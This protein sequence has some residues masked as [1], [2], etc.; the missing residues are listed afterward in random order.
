MNHQQPVP[1][2]AGT[3]L[4]QLVRGPNSNSLGLGLGLDSILEKIKLLDEGRKLL[5][6]SYNKKS[7]EKINVFS[8]FDNFVVGTRLYN[9][10]TLFPLILTKNQ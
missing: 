3:W 4:H 8:T 5:L 10:Y 2:V 1:T 7:Y 6:C 9:L